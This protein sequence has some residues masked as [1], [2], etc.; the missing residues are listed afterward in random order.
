MIR[1]GF[2]RSLA[3]LDATPDG[4]L[5]TEFRLLRAGVNDTTEGPV[6]FD[7]V[8]A[9]SVMAKFELRGNDVCIDLQHDS[10]DERARAMR[11]DAAD[12]RGY[13]K[14]A[15]RPAAEPVDGAR[16]DL[17]S[18]AVTWNPDGERRLRERTQRYPSP[19]VLFDDSGEPRAS[20]IFNVALVSMPAT[21]SAAALV[22]ARKLESRMDP[23]LIQGALDALIEGNAEAAM[24]L[25]KQ[26]IAAAAGAEGEAAEPLAAEDAAADPPDPKPEKDEVAMAT[27]LSAALRVDKRDVLAEVKRMRTELDAL[28]LSRA[29][30][31]RNERLDL[32]GQLVK[33]GAELPA[34]AWANA[35][36]RVPDPMYAAMPIAALRARVAA[37]AAAPRPAPIAPPRGVDGDVAALSDSDRARA[38][39][40]TD[41]NVRERFVA[42][43]LAH[44]GK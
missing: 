28:V 30:D 22:A 8:A 24:E 25:L 14:L 5:P 3:V 19:V 34:T 39:K 20:E 13:C 31:E 42:A 15:L 2:G 18:V 26:M 27:A 35:D 38:A 41:T 1:K 4:T 11:S 44:G 17:W 6:L 16:Y 21:H 36:K 23:K 12:A 9:A 7:D 32:V 37:F 33:L 29:A 10:I 40:M 43:R